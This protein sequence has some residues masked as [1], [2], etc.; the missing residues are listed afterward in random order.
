M[1]LDIVLHCI[2]C[3]LP[4]FFLDY[5]DHLFFSFVVL[6]SRAS[7]S[8]LLTHKET[9]PVRSLVLG[10][11]HRPGS[12]IIYRLGPLQC[13][14]DSKSIIIFSQQKMKKNIHITFICVLM[15][16]SW[17]LCRVQKIFGMQHFLIRR[18]LTFTSPHSMESWAQTFHSCLKLPRSPESSWKTWA[19]KT[20]SGLNSAVSHSLMLW[21]LL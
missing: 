20:S 1:V 15:G 21:L 3:I 19:S 7:D 5:F 17:P 9:L 8:G 14:G 16:M 6:S 13:H 10:D 12:E 11:V 2:S 18:P 4:F